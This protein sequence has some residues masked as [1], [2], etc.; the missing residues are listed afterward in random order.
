MADARIELLLRLIDQGYDRKAWH[1]PNLRGSIRG[2]TAEEAAWRPAAGRHNVWEIVVHAAYWKYAVR[3]RLLGEK[4]GSFPI[5]GSNWFRRPEHGKPD[6]AQWKADVKMLGEIHRSM[7]AAV[8]GLD[9]ATLEAIPE[10]G[11]QSRL[12]LVMGIAAHDI[13]HAGQIQVL[14]RLRAG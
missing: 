13:Y 6:E 9:P 8:A 2:L 5:I 1:G 10:G 3:R 4:R 7:R 11:K 12:T 14:K